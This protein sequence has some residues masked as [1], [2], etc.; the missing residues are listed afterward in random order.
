ML[1]I[2]QIINFCYL[3]WGEIFSMQIFSCSYHILTLNLTLKIET[4]FIL[5]H[6][7]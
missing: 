7:G 1:S 4:L 3:A 5:A 6:A 2:M